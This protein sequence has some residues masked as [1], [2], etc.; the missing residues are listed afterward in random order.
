MVRRDGARSAMECLGAAELGAAKGKPL[1]FV[2]DLLAE[3]IRREG[4]SERT[5]STIRAA[6]EHTDPGDQGSRTAALRLA[7]AVGFALSQPG[8]EG[9]SLADCFPDTLLGGIVRDVAF[10]V[11]SVERGDGLEGGQHLAAAAAA[12]RTHG[13]AKGTFW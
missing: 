1:V 8:R 10:G 13:W 5:P 6:I 4:L 3:V 12:A 7:A 9:P 2:L 11:L